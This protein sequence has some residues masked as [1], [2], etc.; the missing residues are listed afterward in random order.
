MN[1]NGRPDLPI[2]SVSLD[3]LRPKSSLRKRLKFIDDTPTRMSSSASGSPERSRESGNELLLDLNNILRAKLTIDDP[4]NRNNGSNSGSDH[5]TSHNNKDEEFKKKLGLESDVITRV[6]GNGNEGTNECEENDEEA[7]DNDDVPEV[8]SRATKEHR[9][10][11]E[12]DSDEMGDEEDEEEDEFA[13]VDEIDGP[14]SGK[15]KDNK[16]EAKGLDIDYNMPIDEE[17]K[18]SLDERAAEFDKVSRFQPISQP[19]IEWSL[20]DFCS[21]QD[22]LAEWFCTS[23][24]SQLAQ[25]K[26]QFDKK[27]D[28][29][30]RFLK[31][32]DYALKIMDQLC[33]DTNKNLLAL[34]YISMGTFALVTSLDEQLQNIRRNNLMLCSHLNSIVDVFKKVAIAC[35][36]NVTNLKRETTLFFY[37][38]TILFFMTNVCIEQRDNDSNTVKNAIK[39]LHDAQLLPFLTHYIEHW[40]WNSRL[41][42][43]IRNVINLLFRLLVLQ[44][45]DKTVWKRSKAFLYNLHNLKQP[46]RSEKGQILTISPLHYQAFREDITARFPDHRTPLAGLPPEV[47]NSNSLSQFLEIPRS[48]AKNP[49]NLTLAT[50]QQHIATPAPSPPGSPN[51]LQ[52][53]AIRHRKSF[54]TNMA[55]PCLYP[56]DDEEGEDELSKKMSLDDYDR[57]TEVFVPYSIQEATNILSNS[58]H[59]KLSV[60]Q[61]WYERD[62]FIS[63]ERGWK[64]DQGEDKYNY[65]SMENTSQEESIDIMKRVDSFYDECFSSLNSLVFVLLQTVESNLSNVDFRNSDI[66]ADTKIDP[67]IPRLEITRAKELAMKSSFGIL[68]LLLRWFKLNHVLKQEHL[69][70]LLHDSRYIQVCCSLL[71]KYSE[72]YPDKAFNRMLSSPGSI[73]REC[74]NY[75]ST[76]Q[77]SLLDQQDTEKSQNY[78][79]VTLSSLAYMLKVLR[80]IVGNK[81]ERLKE[82]PLNIGLLFKRYYRIFNIDIYHPILRIIKELTPF[83]NKRWKAEHMELISGV[84]LYEEL[85]LIDNWVTGK[86]VS[87][88]LGDAC[89]QE[90]AM[91]ALLQFYNFLHYEK[92]MEDLGY[93]QRS[94]TNLSLL[95][96]ESEYL[97]M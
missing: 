8:N 10:S 14:I 39:I 20:Q 82:L 52:M 29:P 21:L 79:T 17:Y 50:P 63:T 55:Y 80:R 32:D 58:V 60:Q 26:S 11:D 89:G 92:S 28:E 90:I 59:I 27:V 4:R 9:L 16:S 87:G 25:T 84:F 33:Q 7:D 43:R 15:Q 2:R 74:S 97:G 93:S 3:N 61:L 53:D 5:R 70:V 35:R 47:D 19:R 77:Q 88:E 96:K 54:Q 62:L 66:P 81:T 67:L 34:T 18:K 49:V 12:Q 85:E 23:D 75:N 41:S 36:D 13:N 31:D 73:W 95:N 68:Y 24:F 48:K 94:T 45:G 65:S 22:E 72:N 78:D 71:S 30:Q 76:Y 57:R 64:V 46:H 51:L 38:C 83:K 6:Y 42:M 44:F 37:S 69:C 56:S 91:R 86:D 40:R 1:G